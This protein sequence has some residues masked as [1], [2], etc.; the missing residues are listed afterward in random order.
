MPYSSGVFRAGMADA[1]PTITKS[2][3]W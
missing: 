1:G 3:M 2:W